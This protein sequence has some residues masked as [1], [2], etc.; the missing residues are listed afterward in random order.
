MFLDVHG[1]DRLE[2]PKKSALGLAVYRENLLTSKSEF[3]SGPSLVAG[4]RR[5]T[6]GHP[7]PRRAEREF[8]SRLSVVGD[9]S[10]VLILFGDPPSRAVSFFALQRSS[11]AF[12]YSNVQFF[13]VLT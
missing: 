5:C 7:A 3:V 13:D 12:S 4:E 6:F 9:V 10:W 1:Q 11:R 2:N 8:E